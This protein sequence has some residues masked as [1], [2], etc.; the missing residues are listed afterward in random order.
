MWTTQTRGTLL[1][2]WAWNVNNHQKSP[3]G[4]DWAFFKDIRHCFKSNFTGRFV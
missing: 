3:I 4:E 2:Y 1:T